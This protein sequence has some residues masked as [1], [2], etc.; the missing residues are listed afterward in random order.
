MCY[1]ETFH[2]PASNKSP[3]YGRL[4]VRPSKSS[5][6]GSHY[7]PIKSG[8]RHV[9]CTCHHQQ[10]HCLL[11]FQSARSKAALILMRLG[12]MTCYQWL[13]LC[14]V[15]E[16]PTRTVIAFRVF[17]QQ[18][19]SSSGDS[20]ESGQCEPC[21]RKTHLVLQSYEW[22]SKLEL[23]AISSLPCGRKKTR[24]LYKYIDSNSKPP[25]V[26]SAMLSSY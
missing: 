25:K 26:N 7:C 2:T 13:W 12:V 6:A 21:C 19:S 23:L 3:P 1:T 11:H 8:W 16:W 17:P 18:H 9:S 22:H 24:V 20:T 15:G 4:W 5:M 14:A 10:P